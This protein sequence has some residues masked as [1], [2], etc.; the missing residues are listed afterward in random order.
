ME[1]S[2]G[3]LVATSSWLIS[4][5]FVVN[6]F[7]Q[8]WD[9][10]A[11]YYGLALGVQEGNPLVRAG[12][13]Q[14]GAG[15]ALLSAKGLACGLLFVLRAFSQYVLCVG[16]LLLTAVSYFVFSFLPWCVLLFLG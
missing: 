1:I 4:L 10:L 8:T 13:E 12:I 15:W 3:M 5:L 16:G 2:W 11:T 7:L 9:G 6:L 14:L